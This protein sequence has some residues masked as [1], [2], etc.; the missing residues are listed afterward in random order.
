MSCPACVLHV[1]ALATARGATAAVG[2][3]MKTKILGLVAV[4]LLAGPMA[5]NAG[6]LDWNFD[7]GLSNGDAVT[8][9]FVTQS[10]PAGGPYLITSILDGELNGIVP[11]TLLAPGSGANHICFNDNLLSTTVPQ[12][13]ACGFGFTAQGA[14]WAIW[15]QGGAAVDSWCNNSVNNQSYYCFG[16]DPSGSVT[17]VRVAP[18]VPEPA[19]LSLLGLGLA[20]VGF[21]RRRKKG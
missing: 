9:I 16:A 1:A 17:A 11:I 14:E 4:G 15:S 18:S 19:T 20:G 10:T 8:G 3:D 5:A 2:I 6:P 12:L 21:M 7:F 13:D